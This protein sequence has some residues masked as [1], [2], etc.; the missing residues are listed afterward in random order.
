MAT[1]RLDHSVIASTAIDHSA[2]ASTTRL[3]YS[4]IASRA[5]LDHSAMASSYCQIKSFGYSRGTTIPRLINQ[6]ITEIL[7][8]SSRTRTTA[9]LDYSSEWFSKFYKSTLCE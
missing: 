5:R 6:K 7:D 2:I 9:R 1:A 8:H 4:A 3:D